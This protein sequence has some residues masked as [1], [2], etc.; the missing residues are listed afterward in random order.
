MKPTII[1]VLFFFFTH[2]SA[3][4][5]THIEPTTSL[6]YKAFTIVYDSINR[7]RK[8]P[9]FFPNSNI[10]FTY[11]SNYYKNVPVAERTKDDHEHQRSYVQTTS[12]A[13]YYYDEIYRMGRRY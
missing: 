9:V 12:G 7:T 4:R 13:I 8:L 2:A 6:P 3:Q 5:L 10:G 11:C 1:L